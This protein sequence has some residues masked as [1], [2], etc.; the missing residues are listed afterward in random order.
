M[1]RQSAL[2]NLSIPAKNSLAHNNMLVLKKI[3]FYNCAIIHLRDAQLLI[4]T[5]DGQ[6]LNIPPESLCYV[7]KNTVMDVALK[8]LGSEFLMRFTTLIATF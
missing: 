3:R 6:T 5:K 8:V 1:N 4:R 7:E 2:S